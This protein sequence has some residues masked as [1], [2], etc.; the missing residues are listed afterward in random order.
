M[1]AITRFNFFGV[2]SAELLELHIINRVEK[3][4]IR[5]QQRSLHFRLGGYLFVT[6]ATGLVIISIFIYKGNSPENYDELN[7][8]YKRI[9]EALA[10]KS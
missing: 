6:I 5:F 7:K 1:S 2:T 3:I 8:L 9:D 10:K 4:F